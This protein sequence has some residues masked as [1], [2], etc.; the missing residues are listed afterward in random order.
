MVLGT[1]SLNNLF[2]LGLTQNRPAVLSC[3]AVHRVLSSSGRLAGAILR[4]S[5]IPF[6]LEVTALL[7]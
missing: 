7:P 4:K 3:L 2:I 5:Y 1:V 6:V